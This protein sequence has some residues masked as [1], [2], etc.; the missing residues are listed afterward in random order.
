MASTEHSTMRAPAGALMVCSLVAGLLC[1]AQPEPQKALLPAHRRV[2]VTFDDL[3]TVSVRPDDADGRRNMT[4]RLLAAVTSEKL[5]AV[6]FVNEGKLYPQGKLDETRIALLQM[7]LD[8][9]LELGN[10][11][12]SHSDLHATKLAD[13]EQD[14]VRGETVLGRLAGEHG[15]KLRYFRHPMLHTGRDVETRRALAEFLSKRGYAIAPVTIDNS[16]WIFAG[17]YA[18]GSERGD[19]AMKERIVA[20][21]IPYMEQKFDYYERQSVVLLGREPPQILL[22]HANSLNADTFDSLAR[23]IR[24]RGYD[25]ITLAAALQDPAY[26]LPDG[27]YGPAG[28]SWLHRWVLASGRKELIVPDE[29]RT[30]EFVMKEAGVSEE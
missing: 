25:F 21:F 16:D 23:M 5:P 22:L 24:A 12:Y 28:I 27:Y 13:Y 18:S 20:A 4:R 1:F 3:P 14:I 29:P 8:A 17:A 26:E 11:T 15:Q 9:G 10:H 30:P 19:S 7:W 2:A 6:G